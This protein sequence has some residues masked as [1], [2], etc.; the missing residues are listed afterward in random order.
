[1]KKELSLC[2][3]VIMVSAGL[4]SAG[5]DSGDF[6]VLE[7]PYLGQKPP[8]KTPEIFAPGIV[9]VDDNFEHSAAVFSP[10]GKEVFWCTNVD[11]YTDK[12]VAGRLRLYTMKMFEGKWTAP[13]PAPF[14]KNIRVERPVFSPDGNALYIEYGRDPFDID[15]DADIYVVERAGG[16]WSDPKPISPLINS[17]SM[18]RLHCVTR[19]GSIYF[20]RDP[21][22]AR[23]EV[24]VSRWVNGKF[25]APEKLGKS[26][27]SD[28]YELAIVV[29]PDEEYMLIDT[30]NARHTSSELSILY[31]KP[32]G[33]WTERI[34]VEPPRHCGGFLALSPDGKYL[35]F[36]NEAICWMSTS[37]VE[38][39][40]PKNLK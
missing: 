22:T 24:Y 4:F 20:S 15:S 31:K 8:G 26:Y 2:L 5:K 7:G 27:N 33:T 37:F 9:S 13:Q 21:M 35:F 34:R 39:L 40:K 3:M 19:D 11:W 38:E 18:E 1:M 17:S 25:T 29:A 32:D 10:D 30:L 6:P 12:K 16:E 23:E 14:V 36:L 28:G